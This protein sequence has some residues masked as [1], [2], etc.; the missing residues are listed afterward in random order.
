MNNS[1]YAIE[2]KNY[3]KV[4]QKY[5]EYFKQCDF[6]ES[7]DLFEL[8]LVTYNRDSYKQSLA[9]Q[10]YKTS[11]LIQD[12]LDPIFREHMLTKNIQNVIPIVQL[13]VHNETVYYNGCDGIIG[14]YFKKPLEADTTITFYTYNYDSTCY[15]FRRPNWEEKITIPKGTKSYKL[16]KMIYTHYFG[17]QCFCVAKPKDCV[18][19]GTLFC[20]NNKLKT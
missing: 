10:F 5:D 20:I 12:N 9:V 4:L 1:P 15:F 13:N 3:S 16:S 2:L 8:G 6:D 17:D 7:I 11:G 18:L 19:L 14:F